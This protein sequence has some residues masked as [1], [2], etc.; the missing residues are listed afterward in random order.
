MADGATTN[1]S[2]AV[3]PTLPDFSNPIHQAAKAREK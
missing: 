1:S 3:E 2:T